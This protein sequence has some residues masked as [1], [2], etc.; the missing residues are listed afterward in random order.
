MTKKLSYA[1]QNAMVF[2][3][4]SN[5]DDIRIYLKLLVLLYADDTAVFGTDENDFKII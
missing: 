1:T 3:L 2:S 4:S 5:N